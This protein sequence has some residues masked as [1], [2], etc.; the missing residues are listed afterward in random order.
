MKRSERTK[1]S[2]K[3]W[4][5]IPLV[6]ILLAGLGIGGYAFS[7]YN[8]AK[9]TV[10]EKMNTP[11]ESIDRE[12]G[13]KKM[14]AT[15]PLNVLLLGVDEREG[16]SGRSDAL[17]VLSLDPKTDSMRL[18]SI[19]RDT[20]TTISGKGFEDKINHAYAYGG[21]DMSIATVEDFLDIDL[22]YYVQVNMEGLTE[23]VDELGTITVDNDIAWN[24]GTY[25][26]NTGP[27]EMDG[28]KTMAFVRMRKQD[29]NGDFGRA[30]RQR[31]V[32]EGI[33]DE[34]AHVGS[35]TKINDTIDILGNNMA[36]NLDFEDMQKLLSGYADTRKNFVSYQMEGSG[37]NIDGVY[38]L[39]VDETEVE[40]V[41]GMVEKKET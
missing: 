13:K 2:R 36:T 15:K 17:M 14:Q 32:V 25:D 23:L 33:I 41:H 24:D 28:D 35:V 11:V 3:L 29:P 12:V 31:Q 22:D 9:N 8:N 16:D 30:D 1:K 27:V 26:F 4:L 21:A 37:T 39:I 40:K 38:Y 10:N 20:R 19:P 6:I 7:I 34:G 5:K 18:V